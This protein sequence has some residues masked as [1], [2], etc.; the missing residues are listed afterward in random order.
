MPTQVYGIPES[1]LTESER[2]DRLQASANKALSDA[3]DL[4]NK[5]ESELV[6]R[7]IQPKEDLGL[8]NERWIM[9]SGDLTADQYST[10]ID[11][12]VDDGK[13]IVITAIEVLDADP[14]TTFI[15]F[16]SGATTIQQLG[17]EQAYAQD[18]PV[19]YMNSPVVYDEHSTIKVAIYTEDDTSDKNIVLKGYT[20]ETEGENISPGEAN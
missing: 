9:D 4:L 2:L 12:E 20:A 8:D 18:N 6:V 16:S 5:S 13:F 15:Q 17:L 1:V 14:D 7:D 11:K 3:V 19:L 10:V